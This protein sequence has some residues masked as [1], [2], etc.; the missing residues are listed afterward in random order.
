MAHILVVDDDPDLAA[1]LGDVL[2]DA[3]HAVDIAHD[4]WAGLAALDKALPDVVLLDVEMPTLDGPGMAY[5]MFVRDAGRERIPIILIS[6]FVGLRSIARKIGTPYL[7]PKPCE[8]DRLLELV[9][10]ALLE[11]AAPMPDVGMAT[12]Y[13]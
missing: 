11:K 5:E 1:A 2:A 10:R 9:N 7:L 12:T 3:G 13:R 6:A 8:L 4:G